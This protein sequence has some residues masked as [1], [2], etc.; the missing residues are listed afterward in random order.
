MHS[1]LN[2]TI[3]VQL[4]STID[5]ISSL[6][7][8]VATLTDLIYQIYNQFQKQQFKIVSELNAKNILQK[9]L[10]KERHTHV[11]II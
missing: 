3:K 1:E 6:K 9:K 7:K 10:S 11:S 5:L 2:E 4:I 8:K